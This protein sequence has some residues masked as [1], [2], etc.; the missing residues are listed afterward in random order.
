MKLLMNRKLYLEVLSV[1]FTTSIILLSLIGVQYLDVYLSV[2]IIGFFVINAIFGV[3]DRGVN[4]IGVLL[5][6]IFCYLLFLKI[7]VIVPVL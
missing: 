7:I 3:R 2:F 4:L 6:L 5:F 1:V